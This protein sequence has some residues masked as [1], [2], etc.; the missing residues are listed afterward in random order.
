M[1][2]DSICSGCGKSLRVGDEF[3]GRKARCPVCQ[4]IYV[5]SSSSIQGS[6]AETTYAQ[7]SI[8][9]LPNAV[10]ADAQPDFRSDQPT[11]YD[12]VSKP[13]A[14]NGI[15]PSIRPIEPSLF[16]VRTPSS[17]V[18]GP[19]D[20]ATVDEW[21]L[22]GRLD[23]TCH[24][25]VQDSE[26]W[27]GI[28]AW[29]YQ[30]RASS[31]TNSFSS[32]AS[33]FVAPIAANQ[34]SVSPSSGNGAIVLV[35]GILSWV[36]CPGIAAAIAVVMGMNSLKSIRRGEGPASERTLILIGLWLGILNLAAIAGSIGLTILI[37]INS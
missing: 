2:I 32:E 21:I 16:Y 19:A 26:Q 14:S 20:S 4:T 31:P 22:Q 11:Q 34:S 33:H 3:L 13:D 12:A 9:S 28:P 23:D 27:I 25:R 24:V 18:Y 35:A 6:I 1:P 29:R 15:L 17:S 8:E 37:A 36:L 30:Q 7:P 10:L 5:V